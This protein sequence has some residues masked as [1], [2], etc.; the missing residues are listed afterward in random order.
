M[1]GRGAAAAALAALALAACASPA[2]RIEARAAAHGFAREVVAGEPF[3][4]LVYTRAGT[5]RGILH[6]YIEHDG[7]PWVAEVHVAADPTPRRPLML[8]LMALDAGPALY[9]GR[10]CHFGLQDVRCAPAVWTD[11]RYAPEVVDSMAAALARILAGR[12]PPR[13]VFFG[14]SGGGTLAVLL[15]ERFPQAVAVVTVG[16]NLDVAGW[17]RLHRYSPLTGSLDPRLRPSLPAAVLQR[18]Y[19]GSRDTTVPP[20]LVQGYAQ[21]RPG[22]EVVEIAGYDHVCCWQER[23]PAILAGLAERL[24]AR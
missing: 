11:R 23:W 8:E 21:G 19:V 7:T 16:A 10:P 15:A 20:A 1:A 5:G 18:H 9:L 14:H 17:S 6:V 22:V 24:D 3:R 12:P 2:A 13:L 4:H